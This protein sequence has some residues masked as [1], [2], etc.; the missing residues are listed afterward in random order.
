MLYV[1]GLLMLYS[2]CSTVERCFKKLKNFFIFSKFEST[3]CGTEIIITGTIFIMS[4]KTGF[5]VRG[6]AWD[7]SMEKFSLMIGK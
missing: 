7:E 1:A 6:R 4:L 3:L 5:T 2:K